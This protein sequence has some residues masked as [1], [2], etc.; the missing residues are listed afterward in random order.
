MPTTLQ[1]PEPVPTPEVIHSCPNCAHWLVD[2]TLACPDC[3]TLTYSAHLSAIAA[4]AQALEQANNLP[5]ARDRW[6]SA[7]QWLPAD[8]Q[9]HAGIQQHIAQLDA[10]LSAAADKEA[11]WKK[12]LGPFAPIA[13]FLLK[14]KSFVFVLFKFKFLLSFLAY[15]GI[16]W[17]LF[18]WRFAAGF[19]TMLLIHEMGHYVAVK[20]RGLKAE[21]PMFIP[22]MGAYV[23]WYHQGISRVDLAAIALAG[24]LY[25]LA[26]ALAAGALFWGTHAP[27]WLVLANT[28]AWI[29]LLNL[30][31]VLGLDGSQAT[32]AL[33]PAQRA[34][35]AATCFVFF[36]LTVSLSHGDL[37]APTTHW[38]FAIVGAGMVYRCFTADQPEV[39]STTTM[40]YFLGLL[41]TLG[42]TLLL[43]PVPG[44]R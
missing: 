17:A 36:G 40:V 13:L 22:M 23:R 41:L 14:A 33:S 30:V 9:Q 35:V 10:R 7:L 6:A 43:T 29:N 27:I 1:A 20:R 44:L 11:R 38:L 19:L 4:S 3:Q 39:P 2:G 15:F 8:S 32:Y 34:M 5:E 26:A 18:G 16:Y 37:F 12:R 25:G 28:G 21:L 31:P 24:P 42:F